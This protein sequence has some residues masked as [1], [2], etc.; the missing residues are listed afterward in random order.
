MRPV[1]RAKFVEAEQANA[2]QP[3]FVLVLFH[4]GHRFGEH[5]PSQAMR[6]NSGHRVKKSK[7]WQFARV[8][9]RFRIFLK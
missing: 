9:L 7:E 8:A 2:K 4:R 3:E 1:L 6:R 5:R